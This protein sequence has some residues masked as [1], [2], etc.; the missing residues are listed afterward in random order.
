MPISQMAP[1]P[2][3]D[4]PSAHH[5]AF[6]SLPVAAS[7]AEP[8]SCAD[9]AGGLYTLIDIWPDIRFVSPLRQAGQTFR[10]SPNIDRRT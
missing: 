10:I 1:V 8:V 5:V 7:V 9:W 6:V 2:Q 3:H 4:Q